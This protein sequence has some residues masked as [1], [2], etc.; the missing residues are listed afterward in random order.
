[1]CVAVIVVVAAYQGGMFTAASTGSQFS[2]PLS[3]LTAWQ[4]VPQERRGN[5]GTID[6]PL[7]L[8]NKQRNNALMI[9]AFRMAIGENW[10]ATLR[11]LSTG[12]QV[13]LAAVVDKQG[14][15]VSKASEMPEGDF[16][17]RCWDN[18]IVRGRV[19]VIDAELDLALIQ[20]DR[21]DLIPVK[22]SKDTVLVAGAW[23]G[24][25]DA[26]EIPQ[27]IGVVSVPSRPV[28]VE[29]AILGVQLAPADAGAAVVSVVP[30]SGAERAGIEVD[31][32]IYEVNG[33]KLASRREVLE[34]IAG[35]RA[36]Q[37]LNLAVRR[38]DKD[39]TMT[40]RLMD[41]TP[42]ILDPAELEVNGQVSARSSG[43]LRVIQ[44][45]TVLNPNQ[46]GG[47]L[48]G[49]NGEVVGINIARASRVS[50]YALPTDLVVET[51]ERLMKQSLD[52]PAE[53]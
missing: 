52:T 13:A 34:A 9:R 48:V 19:K 24:T 39:V 53:K 1:M 36:G 49:L 18:R 23:V 43:F 7:T 51:I 5:A 50:S 10:K 47:P 3:W 33:R 45:D 2:K 8:S 21:Q 38:G 27:A 40:A 28:A 22:W 41:L 15:A 6:L 16:D 37:R 44:H 14:W 30:G 46:C 31:D 42:A 26:R 20:V 17:C 11:I 29:R 32:V 4:P 25:T 12:R 35:Y